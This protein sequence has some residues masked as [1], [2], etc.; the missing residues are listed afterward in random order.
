VTTTITDPGAGAKLTDTYTAG[1][2]TELNR[3]IPSG[4]TVATSQTSSSTAYTDLATVGPAVT[5][6]TTDTALVS[7]SSLI[8][9]GTGGNGAF[10]AFA[11]SGATTVAANDAQ[12]ISNP[13]TSG[14]TF[15]STFLITGLTPGSNTFTAKYRVAGG[16]AGTW[17]SRS[18]VV[19][20]Y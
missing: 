13:T 5:V 14:W 6:T 19:T 18:I 12:A 20:P 4:A 9:T 15:G 1:V 11:I 8:A 17:V 3:R 10:M 16:T 7:I 2:A